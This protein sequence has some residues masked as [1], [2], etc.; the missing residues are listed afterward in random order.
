MSAA[1]P[2]SQMT[3]QAKFQA[4]LEL[5]EDLFPTAAESEVPAW[6]LELLEETDR[7]YRAGLEIPEDWE[8]V[9]ERMK[10]ALSEMTAA[11]V[12]SLGRMTGLVFVRL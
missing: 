8:I 7:R 10:S 4:Y 12:F 11:D 6:H 5:E 1:L 9:K 2:L 3:R